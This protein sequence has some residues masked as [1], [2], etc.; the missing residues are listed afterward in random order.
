[1]A[2]VGLTVPDVGAAV[3][4]YGSVLGLTLIH[5]PSAM[6]ADGS[7]FG[8]L[9]QDVF[10]PGFWS[11]T[12]AQMS[13][14]NGV[15]LELFGFDDP[16][17]SLGVGGPDA[18][19]GDDDEDVDAGDAFE[20]WRPGLSHLCFVDPDV[21]ALAARIAGSGGRQRSRV[22]PLFP[23]AEGEGKADGGPRMVYC[24]DSW[25]NPIELFSHSHERTYANR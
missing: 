23:G 13:A 12:I 1:M 11:G 4:W 19:C 10:G 15:G 22:W 17:V 16:P 21:E 20:W 24:A 9:L 14:G 2:H 18:S 5:G 7:A 3:A 8:E 25:E 6:R